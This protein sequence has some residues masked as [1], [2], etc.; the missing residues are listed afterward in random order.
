MALAALAVGR[1]LFSGDL[2]IETT[3]ETAEE[4]NANFI[5]ASTNDPPD[6]IDP[7]KDKHVGTCTAEIVYDGCRCGCAKARTV[8][9]VVD[10]AYPSYECDVDF[11]IKKSGCLPECITAITIEAPPQLTV[12]D[13]SDPPLLGRELSWSGEEADGSLWVHVEQ[14]AQPSSTYEFTVTLRTGLWYKCKCNWCH[15]CHWCHK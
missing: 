10:N 12:L 7:G 6:T 13:I 2:S 5:A 9:V 11:T 8:R 3:V 1:A 4:F 14:S 15:D